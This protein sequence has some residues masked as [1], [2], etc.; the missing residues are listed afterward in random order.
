MD[1]KSLLSFTFIALLSFSFLGLKARAAEFE[2]RDDYL[3][4]VGPIVGGDSEQFLYSL[5]ERTS[6]PRSIKLRSPGGL[7]SEALE[8]GRMIRRYRLVTSAPSL[9]LNN[10]Y[11]PGNIG[12]LHADQGN[13]I[14]ASSCAM[15]W[16]GGIMR[17][18]S[19]GIHRSYLSGQVPSFEDY[20]NDLQTSHD[21]IADY[22]TE[23]RVPNWV[24]DKI[25]E[26]SSEELTIISAST[27][28]GPFE[29]WKLQPIIIDAIFQEYAL[30]MCGDENTPFYENM[31]CYIKAVQRA[32]AERSDVRW[33]DT[34]QTYLD[35]FPR[36]KELPYLEYFDAQVRVI[37]SSDDF[38]KDSWLD[39]LGRAHQRTAN[40]FLEIAEP[41][42]W[43]KGT[44]H[45][46]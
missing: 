35:A 14:C 3:Y 40:K 6:E 1:F 13:C 23:M 37:T 7:V 44:G 26:T 2:W 21:S 18:G 45:A 34:A 33:S 46:D 25:F 17:F 4:I 16:L 42:W 19:V 22:L 41:T 20:E 28:S 31:G 12:K 11:C 27:P 10:F 43:R 30:A 24:E 29:P 8:I 39:Q 9:P 36:L 38:M 5:A 32:Q 15:I